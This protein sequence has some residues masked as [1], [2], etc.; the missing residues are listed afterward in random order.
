MVWYGVERHPAI[1]LHFDTKSIKN[2]ESKCKLSKSLSERQ[3]FW[4]IEIA[5][6][7]QLYSS[8]LSIRRLS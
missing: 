6:L 4:M 5:N 3:Q 8:N 2:Y 7:L 1:E